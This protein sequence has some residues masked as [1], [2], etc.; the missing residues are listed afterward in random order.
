MKKIDLRPQV[1]SAIFL[2]FTVTALA[3]NFTI[4]FFSIN[5][6]LVELTI[7]TVDVATGDF[8]GEA[9]GQRP[10]ELWEV[11]GTMVGNKVEI[12]FSNLNTSKRIL[13]AGRIDKDGVIIGKAATEE[14]ELTE[15]EA[16]DALVNNSVS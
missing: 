10:G 5:P 2:A 3:T 11:N 14:G 9:V 8:T 1:K 12:E 16:T 15:W 7:D 13:A 4:E 6:S